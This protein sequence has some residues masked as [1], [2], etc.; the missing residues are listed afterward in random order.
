MLGCS[1]FTGK[2]EIILSVGDWHFRSLNG[3]INMTTIALTL[4][5][6]ATEALLI[7][8]AL[9]CMKSTTELTRNEMKCKDSPQIVLF[10]LTPKEI[11]SSM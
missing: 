5:M 11:V 6:E 2:K 4:E 1:L 9:E 10:I 3:K 8:L 7:L